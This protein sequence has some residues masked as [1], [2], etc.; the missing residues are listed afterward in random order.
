MQRGPFRQLAQ[1]NTQLPGR[2]VGLS[3]SPLLTHLA[4]V[5][6]FGVII[7]Y[8]YVS[9]GSGVR[10]LTPLILMQ[11]LLNVMRHHG[12]LFRRIGCGRND[13]TSSS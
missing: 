4:R 3:H 10:R 12:H 6:M 8:I 9:T 7:V 1:H 13:I 11:M 5:G 2:L